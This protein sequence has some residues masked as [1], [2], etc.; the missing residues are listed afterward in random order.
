VTI[1]LA[2]IPLPEEFGLIVLVSIF[3]AITGVFVQSA[4]NISTCAEEKFG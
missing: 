1:V 2:R 4:F 3:I